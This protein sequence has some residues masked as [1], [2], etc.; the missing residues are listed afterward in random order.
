M[1]D[2]DA[3]K[4]ATNVAGKDLA[5]ATDFLPVLPNGGSQNDLARAVVSAD[6]RDHG[7]EY[8][9]IYAQ[10]FG[11]AGL[12]A[13]PPAMRAGLEGIRLPDR[14]AAAK[15]FEVKEGTRRPVAGS[16]RA[17]AEKFV[18]DNATAL[19]L[20]KG[21]SYRAQQLYHNDQGE[22]FITL[23]NGA[24]SQDDAATRFLRMGFD[25]D[26]KIIHESRQSLP[27]LPPA[28]GLPV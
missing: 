7:G 19:Q 16:D 15:P 8:G 2:D 1:S 5:R 12:E 4:Q 26:G 10:N 23:S 27:P 18:K 25:R 11:T 21:V 6:R 17:A 20:E 13:E 22:T 28:P 24:H 3:L 9:S 14:V